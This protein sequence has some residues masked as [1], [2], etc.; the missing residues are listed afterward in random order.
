MLLSA[1]ELLQ[2]S[3]LVIQGLSYRKACEEFHRLHPDRPKP[4]HQLCHK[5]V[6]RLKQTGSVLP[7]K[8]K[9]SERVATDENHETELDAFLQFKSTASIREMAA[10]IGVSYGSVSNML[11][12]KG[13]KRYKMRPVQTLLIKDYNL[14]FEF[15]DWFR[16]R[17]NSDH[18]FSENIIFSDESTF[19]LTDPKGYQR[20]HQWL[21]ENAMEVYECG[22]QGDVKVNVWCAIHGE[23]I[24]GPVFLPD[25][26]T[27]SAYLAMIQERLTEYLENLSLPRL[28]NVFF[29]QDGAP[30]HNTRAVSEWLNETLPF[31]WIGRNGPIRWPPRS[32][33]LTPLDFFLWGY[34]K[35]RVYLPKATNL[36][37]LKLSITRVCQQIPKEMLRA[38]QRNQVKRINACFDC[39]GDVFEHRLK[40][41]FIRINIL[42]FYH[43]TLQC[44]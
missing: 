37:E 10:H 17:L 1:Q 23:T 24:I 7:R 43:F 6:N 2:L 12:R 25:K 40:H 21:T 18:A 16:S 19:Y 13:Y 32:P 8:P 28:S 22:R 29:Q 5:V 35:K 34:I 39:G 42:Y 11:R 44:Y 30:P 9:G 41:W 4:C 31:H 26:L 36:D 3:L 20:G 27:G 14:R 38:V 33:D 15:C